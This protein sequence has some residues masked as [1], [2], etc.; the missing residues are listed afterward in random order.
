MYDNFTSTY[1]AINNGRLCNISPTSPKPLSRL[2]HLHFLIQ[3][4]SVYLLEQSPTYQG[5]IRPRLTLP[6]C[7]ESSVMASVPHCWTMKSWGSGEVGTG[8]EVGRRDGAIMPRLTPDSMN[9]N[10]QQQS[11]LMP[12][13]K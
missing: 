3:P 11:N 10:R 9:I 6:V 4:V 2:N 1:W 12:L 13:V 5:H 8:K 7:G